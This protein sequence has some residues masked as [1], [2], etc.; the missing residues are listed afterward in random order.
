MFLRRA[1]DIRPYGETITAGTAAGR[2]FRCDHGRAMLV[3]TDTVSVT[4]VTP[5]TQFTPVTRFISSPVGTTTGRPFCSHIFT[6]GRPGGRPIRIHTNRRRR[7]HLPCPPAC[8]LTGRRGRRPLRTARTNLPSLCNG[9]A[10]RAPAVRTI[11]PSL[12]AKLLRD[13]FT[14][15]RFV[16]A[17]PS[18]VRSRVAISPFTQGRQIAR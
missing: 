14:P 6:A 16:A 17:V 12:A 3:P 10:I 11:P 8:F 5:V 9:A 7:D 18:R 2:P 1:D 13:V 4:L 15:L